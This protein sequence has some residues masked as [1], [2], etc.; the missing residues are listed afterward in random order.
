MSRYLVI[1]SREQADLCDHLREAF[2]GDDKV[3][4]IVDRRG[5]ERRRPPAGGSERWIEHRT[6]SGVDYRL[7]T[8][9]FAIVRRQ[10]SDLRSEVLARRT[11]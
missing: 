7:Q 10:D 6:R 4:I 3:E 9:G 1:V 11:D 5:G 2:V 8:M